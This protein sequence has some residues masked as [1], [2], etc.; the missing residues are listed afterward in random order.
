MPPRGASCFINRFAYNINSGGGSR[1][2]T[3][4]DARYLHFAGPSLPADG[5]AFQFCAV[6]VTLT[7]SPSSKKCVVDTLFQVA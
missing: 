2:R 5:R 3:Q 1:E 4:P 7:V 6:L